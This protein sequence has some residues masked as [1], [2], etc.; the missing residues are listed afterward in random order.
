[1]A[2]ER[3]GTFATTQ[4]LLSQLQRAENNLNVT[5]QQVSSGKLADTYTG[6]GDKT[7]LMEAAR[8][9]ADRADA[10]VAAAQ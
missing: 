3:V 5:E 7:A 8:S 6:Y 4:V 9:S 2:I 10:N 1:M